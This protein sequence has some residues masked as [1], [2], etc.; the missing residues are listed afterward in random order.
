M[1]TEIQTPPKPGPPGI[2]TPPPGNGNHG[3]GGGS[4]DP[5]GHGSRDPS[6]WPVPPGAYRT[7]I[8]VAIVSISMLFLALT[9]AMVV[10]AGGSADWV[11]MAV[12]HIVYLNTFILILSSLTF[13]LARRSLRK[14]ANKR[15][16]RW[17]CLTTGL[18][19]TFIAGQLMAWRQLAARGIHVA[20]NPS[21]SFFYVLTGAHGIHVLGGVLVLLYL[22]F[23]T[24]KIIVNPRKRIAVDVTA[25]YWHFIDGLWIYLLILL[26]VKL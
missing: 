2:S 21:S 15:F 17:L 6:N 20:T 9:S 10:R 7:G 4:G 24:R 3:H 18:G 26:T 23:R 1:G 12:P 14:G 11:H 16:A 8:W 5:G 13:E 22:V 25:I 19:I